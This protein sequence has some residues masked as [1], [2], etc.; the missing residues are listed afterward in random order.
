M[1]YV[2]SSVVVSSGYGVGVS[3]QEVTVTI[4]TSSSLYWA[5]AANA[6]LD[7]AKSERMTALRSIVKIL[8]FSNEL[9]VELNE[10]YLGNVENE[11]T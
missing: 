8:N 1:T 7:E 5:G 11:G 3:S 6:S 9:W 4:V 10:G 2:G